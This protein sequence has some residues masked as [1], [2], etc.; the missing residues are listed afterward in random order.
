RVSIAALPLLALAVW[1]FRADPTRNK[2]SPITPPGAG[3]ARRASQIATSGSAHG[4]AA[5]KG[6]DVQVYGEKALGSEPVPS[7]GPAR[8]AAD[9]PLMNES[10]GS[11]GRLRAVRRPSSSGDQSRGS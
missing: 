8:L 3:A 10:P 9:L 4:A 6:S 5:A 11:V 7:A 2:L 1:Y